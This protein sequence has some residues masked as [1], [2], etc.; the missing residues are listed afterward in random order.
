M[1]DPNAYQDPAQFYR[2][3]DYDPHGGEVLVSEAW[4]VVSKKTGHVGPF[5]RMPFTA[6]TYAIHPS[7]EMA[8]EQCTFLDRVIPVKV[9][10]R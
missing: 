5:C 1:Q 6:Y 2:D 9:L 8:N 10:G 4:A 3:F 7:E